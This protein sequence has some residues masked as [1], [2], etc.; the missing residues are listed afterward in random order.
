MNCP[1]CG[2]ENPSGLKFCGEC[3]AKLASSARAGGPSP[4]RPGTAAGPT[5]EGWRTS[6][7]ALP[8]PGETVA[9]R[10]RIESKLGQG[11]MG[12]VFKA[13]DT[14]LDR[15]V[16]VKSMLGIDLDALARF[17]KEAKSIGRLEHPNIVEVLDYLETERGPCLLMKYVEAESLHDRLGREGN[18]GLEDATRILLKVCDGLTYAHKKGVIHRDIKPSNIL[19]TKSGEVKIADFGLA[20]GMGPATAERIGTIGY[21]SP[22]QEEGG[23]IDYRTDIYA[24]GAMYYHLLTGERPTRMRL[25]RVPESVRDLIDRA[26]VGLEERYESVREFRE[27]VDAAAKGRVSDI[28]VRRG[29][30]A[31]G[32][33]AAPSGPAKRSSP[34]PVTTPVLPGPF[35]FRSG[36]RASN[37]EELAS[38]CERNWDDA[39]WHL[40]EGHFEAWLRSTGEIALADHAQ[41]LL[42]SEQG[43]RKSLEAFLTAC[44]S[45]G[46]RIL[47]GRR[48][49]ERRTEQDVDNRRRT[50]DEQRATRE[51]KAAAIRSDALNSRRRIR[52]VGSLASLVVA[53]VAAC[54]IPDPISAYDREPSWD[55]LQTFLP[56]SPLSSLLGG[57]L[58]S[59][60]Q[61]LD[62][63]WRGTSVWGILGSIPLGF[64]AGA[65]LGLV[66]GAV[67]WFIF[68]PVSSILLG[69]HGLVFRL[70]AIGVPVGVSGVCL[71]FTRYQSNIA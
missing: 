50:D 16:A 3:G 29:S 33:T 52:M 62:R 4:A 67:A 5:G 28:G 40:K 21:L 54:V 42:K 35:I 24:L 69:S 34:G 11:G 60:L 22:E 32:A 61:P 10:F 55:V 23:V 6:P 56:A 57:L 58:G 41:R 18:L 17:Q 12:A 59:I 2:V 30:G 46:E 25:E 7:A 27:A 8:Q 36:D 71:V 66:A 44:G 26:T 14:K 70:V 64:L 45:I 39:E 65:L 68:G 43:H 31:E 47:Y 37:L 9:E 15:S 53:A 38:A 48:E 49:A 63:R 1:N 20:R 19:L 13:K 51:A